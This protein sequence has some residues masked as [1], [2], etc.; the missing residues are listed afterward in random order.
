MVDWLEPEPFGLFC[1]YFADELIGGQALQGLQAPPVVVCVDEHRQ[2]SGELLV[3]VVVEAFDGGILDC[4]VHPF[5]LPV[6][7]G[8]LHLCQPALDAVLVAAGVE[9][10]RDVA[11]SRRNVAGR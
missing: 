8:M 2:V 11:G 1:P 6:G 10:V 5:D 9:H 4:S 7:P 3:T